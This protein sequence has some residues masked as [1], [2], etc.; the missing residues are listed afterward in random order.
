[1]LDDT[2]RQIAAFELAAAR[3]HAR[4]NRERATQCETSVREL[5]KAAGI[6]EPLSFGREANAANRE[7]Q[8]RE[9]ERINLF[10]QTGIIK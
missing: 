8:R 1:M 9:R 3:A 2:R 6:P 10:K 5:R 4:G 7:E